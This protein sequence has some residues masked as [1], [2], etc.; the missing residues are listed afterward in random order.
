MRGGCERRGLGIGAIWGISEVGDN[1][2][3]LKYH[4]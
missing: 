1:K 4:L 2:I 3:N